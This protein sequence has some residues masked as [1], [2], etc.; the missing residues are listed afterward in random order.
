MKK[1]I[2]PLIAGLYVAA[3]MPPWGWWPLA[4]LGL[5]IYASLAARP[6]NASPF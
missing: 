3:S 2:A 1:V 5:A 4:F 6:D